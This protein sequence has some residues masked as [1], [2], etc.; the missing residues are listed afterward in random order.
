MSFLQEELQTPGFLDR[1]NSP[2]A[3]GP[4]ERELDRAGPSLN[5]ESRIEVQ[6]PGSIGV[7]TPIWPPVVISTA[8]PRARYTDSI[9]AVSVHD[10]DGG[11]SE[12]MRLLMGPEDHR[13]HEFKYPESH[14][15]PPA[16]M[17]KNSLGGGNTIMAY[18]VFH[19][20][21]FVRPGRYCIMITVRHAVGDDVNSV[22]LTTRPITVVV[23]KPHPAREAGCTLI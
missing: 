22:Q 23:E 8:C 16:H 14:A 21:S 1:A 19:S 15:R 13:S 9:A 3:A 17:L 12:R 18:A 20:L 11:N 10:L 4:P 6:P 7:R 2:D 5:P